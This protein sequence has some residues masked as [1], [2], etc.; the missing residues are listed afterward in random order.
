MIL[1]IA[2]GIKHDQVMSRRRQQTRPQT[3]QQTM[4]ASDE[5]C[6][7]TLPRWRGLL[8]PVLALVFALPLAGCGF[9]LAGSGRL[10]V[11]MQT[12]YVQSTAPRSEFFASLTE[13]L[14]QRGLELVDSDERAGATLTIS[15]DLTG[16]RVLSVSAR[17]IPREYEVYYAVTF[18]LEAEGKSLI[19]AEPLVARRNYSYD[20]TQV[21]GKEREESQL[22]RA[23]AEDLARQVVRRIEAVAGDGRPRAAG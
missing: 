12:T 7:N 15:E 11:A 8:A 5:N 23:L 9:Q 2:N 14:R 17:N 1:G 19:N 21:L 10:P 22:R 18:S 4:S 3:Q 6:T 20:E 13:A 16:Q